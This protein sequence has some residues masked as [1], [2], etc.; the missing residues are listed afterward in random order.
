MNGSTQRVIV[1]TGASAGIGKAAAEAFARMGWHVI[2]IGRDPQRSE[3]AEAEL[4]SVATSPARIDFL[5]GDFCEMVDVRRVA[6]EISEITDHVDILI[7][8]AGGVRDQRYITSE[9]N[10]A[11]FAANHL[12][13]FLL[14]RELMPLL[15]AAAANSPPGSVRVLA[16]S[17]S[18]HEY[19][20]GMN[21]DDLQNL[22]TEEFQATPAYS[23]AKLANILFTRELNRRV[24]ADGIIA[25]SMGPGVVLTNFASYG[26]AAMQA[27]LKDA[28]GATPEEAARTLVWMATSPECGVDGGRYFYELEEKQAAACATNEESARRLWDETEKILEATANA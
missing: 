15:K 9:G 26:D 7:N 18:A 6:G 20:P 22:H 17:S 11:T 3:K 12:A 25:H 16:V 21:W 8:N 23:Q 2:G 14:T 10:E 1:I 13:P 5:R 4:R 24:S 19:I 27:Y 28:P